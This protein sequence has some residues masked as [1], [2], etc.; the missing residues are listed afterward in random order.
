MKYLLDSNVIILA[1]SGA[2]EPLL[3]RL[4]ACDEGDVVTSAIALAEVALGTENGKAPLP[5]RLRLF[6][7][8][9]P[10][11]DFDYK[12]ALA[13]A[14]LP[15]RRG[16]FDRLIAAHALSRRLAVVTGNT[17]HFADI[18]GLRVENWTIA[19]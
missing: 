13:Y 6:V 4:A 11:L 16:G 14:G 8:E 15:F 9:V 7:S 5:D 2:S 12:A 19:A 3:H 1:L 18:P 17:R 10:V